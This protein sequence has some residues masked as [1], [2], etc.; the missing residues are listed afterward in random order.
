M[1]RLLPIVLAIVALATPAAAQTPSATEA[2]VRALEQYEAALRT[3][4]AD[5]DG[6]GEWLGSTGVESDYLGRLST[7][8]YLPDST[9]NRFGRFGDRYGADNLSNPYGRYGNPYSPSSAT[10]PYAVNPPRL[11]GDDGVY[12]GKLS[13][14]PY[15]PESTTNPYGRYGSPYSPDSINNPYGTYGSPFSPLSPNN[16]YATAPPLILGSDPW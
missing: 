16:P 13:T 11:F 12:L 10:N 3:L 6:D 8:P 9:G 5:F 4:A 14:N 1:K 7:N 15:D 2:Y